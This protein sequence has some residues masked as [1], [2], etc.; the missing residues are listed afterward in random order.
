MRGQVGN[1]SRGKLKI[2]E[3]Q[4]GVLRKFFKDERNSNIYEGRK[5]MYNLGRE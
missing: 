5:L 3:I 4:I 1:G 2:L